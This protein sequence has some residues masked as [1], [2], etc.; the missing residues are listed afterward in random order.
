M[1]LGTTL[2]HLKSAF[3][4][5]LIR[6]SAGMFRVCARADK[7]DG[8]REARV[9]RPQ[10]EAEVGRRGRRAGDD[11]SEGAYRG[12]AR[13][14]HGGAARDAGDEAHEVGGR[15][16]VEFGEE[17]AARDDREHGEQRLVRRHTVAHLPKHDAE[18]G[19]KGAREA[20]DAPR[21]LM[22]TRTRTR[23]RSH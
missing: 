12:D 4:L 11:C 6:F 20:S 13:G 16:P 3:V 14:A 5:L 2:L 15:H 18:G 8:R 7:G 22:H 21:T 23:T 9:H 1:A 17:D 10:A 19:G